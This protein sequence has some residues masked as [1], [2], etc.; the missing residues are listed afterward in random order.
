MWQVGCCLRPEKLA[1]F[2]GLGKKSIRAAPK[3]LDGK[4]HP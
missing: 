1:E 2:R 3:I 4:K